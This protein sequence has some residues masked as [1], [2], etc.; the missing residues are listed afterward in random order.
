ML[1]LSF[2]GIC[3]GYVDHEFP[4]GFQLVYTYGYPVGARLVQS[5]RD[6]K[7][8]KGYPQQKPPWR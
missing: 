4:Y 3:L 5:S 8:E 2:Q 1:F 7:C 6:T